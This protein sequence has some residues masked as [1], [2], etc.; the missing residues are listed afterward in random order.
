M[1]R[2][3]R[4]LG[5]ALGLLLVLAACLPQEQRRIPG[6]NNN[7]VTLGLQTFSNAGVNVRA[8]PTTRSAKLGVIAKGETVYVLQ[9]QGNW[10]FVRGA[11]DLRGWVYA[12]YLG[13]RKVTRKSTRKTKRKSSRKSKRKGGAKRRAKAPAKSAPKSDEVVGECK[14]DACAPGGGGAAALPGE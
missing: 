12:K 9:H 13:P 8:N 5:I 7:P 11:A 14:G 6:G 4:H 10:A 3:L 2:V 1:N